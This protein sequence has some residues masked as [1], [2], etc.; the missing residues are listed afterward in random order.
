MEIPLLLFAIC[1]NKHIPDIKAQAPSPE[2]RLV[3][4]ESCEL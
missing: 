4:S 1:Q 3:K 2:S